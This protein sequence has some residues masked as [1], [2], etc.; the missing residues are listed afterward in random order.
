[1]HI[2]RCL[3]VGNTDWGLSISLGALKI[4]Q[5]IIKN[6]LSVKAPPSETGNMLMAALSLPPCCRAPPGSWHSRYRC[7]GAPNVAKE[8]RPS[9]HR[10][11]ACLRAALPDPMQPYS[12]AAP[13]LLRFPLTLGGWC[14]I[15]PEPT[16]GIVGRQWR[17]PK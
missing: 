3:Q 13:A 6:I 8:P 14:A 10:R 17:I 16:E 1:M 4:F 15:P 2:H 5:Q 12:A 7:S 11:Y 9:P